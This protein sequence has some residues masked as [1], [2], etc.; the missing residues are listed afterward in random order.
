MKKKMQKKG[1]FL[2]KGVASKKSFAYIA[3]LGGG[4][5]HRR[6][7]PHGPFILEDIEIFNVFRYLTS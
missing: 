5:T 3:L 6:G 1:F 4:H 7:G 2:K